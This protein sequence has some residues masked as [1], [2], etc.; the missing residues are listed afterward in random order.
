MA[1]S[2]SKL[3]F[4]MLMKKVEA[5]DMRVKKYLELAGYE[6][7][8]RSY[9][10]VHRGW[11]LTSNIAESINGVLVSARELPIYEFLKEV[12]ILFAKWNCANRQEASYTFTTLIE[13]LMT[14]SVRTR[15]C[16]PVV[17]ATKYVYTV[18]DNKSTSLF[19][20]RKK[21]SHT[22]DVPIYPFPH[23]DDWI[24]S[25]NIRDEIVSM[26]LRHH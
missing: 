15:L 9:A 25:E 12:R 14:Y 18:H 6:K 8:A 24:I 17:P 20:S 19:A 2:Y 26:V 22:Y 10:T 7:W 23:S 5:A 21:S 16:V 13:S 4:H 1:K 11:T 3:E